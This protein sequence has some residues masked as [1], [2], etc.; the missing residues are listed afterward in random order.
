MKV[1][2]TGSSGMVGMN[3]INHPLFSK[4]EWL[5]PRHKELDLKDYSQVES[6]L[7]QHKPD[8]IIHAAGKVGGIQANMREPVSFLIDNLDMGRN[9]LL[10]ASKV[11]VKKL[12]NLGS[13]C[14]YPRDREDALS[15]DDVL[16]GQLEPTNEGYA[17]A[18]I[19]VARL[20]SYLNRENPSFMYKTLIPCNLFGPYDKFDPKWSHM[21]PA[22]LLKLHS[23]K[24]NNSESVEIWGSGEA[25]REFMYAGDLAEAIYRALEHI[26]DMPELLNIGLGHDYTVNEYYQAAAKVVGYTG[27]FHHDL[28]KP[29]GMSR[30]LT[31]V[32]K[33]HDWGWH[34]ST[35]LEGGLEKTYQF[36]LNQL[37]SI[38]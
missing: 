15:E 6:Y 27:S 14:M 19:T 28:S 38:N 16:C 1:L 11:G 35:S 10:A 3:I 34:S 36:F 25:R 29:V 26:D 22:V 5:L 4:Y 30:K 33:A 13:S 21:I 31:S 18:K 23:A 37:S 7:S 2:L 24:E 12:L 8:F 32:N 20:A 17:L 9:L